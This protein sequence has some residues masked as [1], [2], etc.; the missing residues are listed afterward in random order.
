MNTGHRWSDT[1]RGKR[2]LEKSM[3]ECHFQHHNSR[4]GWPEIESGYS[5]WHPGV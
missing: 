1:D 5:R 3:S 4:M 2:I